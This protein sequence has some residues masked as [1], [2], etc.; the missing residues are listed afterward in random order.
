YELTIKPAKAEFL[1]SLGSG[2]SF[3]CEVCDLSGDGELEGNIIIQW[4][5]NHNKEITSDKDERV[6]V[7]K[8]GT[9]AKKLVIRRII[10]SDAGDYRCAFRVGHITNSKS[11]KLSVFKDMSFDH[12]PNP[13]HPRIH[14]T[15]IIEC[16]VS[17]VPAPEV[18][19]RFNGKKIIYGDKY[20]QL[21]KGLQIKNISLADNGNYTCIAEI[22]DSGRYDEKRITVVV[23]V[24]P[25]MIH[26][27]GHQ[28]GIAG[29]ELSL[30]CKAESDPMPSYEFYKGKNEKLLT[31]SPSDRIQIDSH[32]GKLTFK[33][34][35]KDDH[36]IY[37]C[38]ALNDVGE[39]SANGSLHVLVAPHIY[40]LKNVTAQEGQDAK[41]TC[42]S[43]GDPM[44][45]MEFQ[46]VGHSPF[47]NGSNDGG[48]ITVRHRPANILEIEIK[49][50]QPHDSSN[51]TCLT[52][53]SAGEHNA[54][55]HLT[56]HYQPKFPSDHIRQV[57]SWSGRL[58][59]I[60]CNAHGNPHPTFEWWHLERLLTNNETFNIFTSARNSSLQIRVREADQSWIFGEYICRAKNNKGSKDMKILHSRASLPDPPSDA[61]VKENTPNLLIINVKPPFSVGG[62]KLLGYRIEYN[63]K[64]T[65]F[66][67]MRIS[68]LLL[69]DDLKMENLKP[70]TQYQFKVRSRNEVGVGKY[71][72]LVAT[73]LNIT[74]PYPI[75]L[76][77]PKQSKD[78]WSYKIV[79]EKPKTGGKPIKEYEIRYRRV[80]M[81][82]DGIS[83]PL[84]NWVSKTKDENAYKPS[85]EYILSNLNPKTNY[86]LQI[87][88]KT[89]IGTSTQSEKFIF[90]TAAGKYITN[91]EMILKRFR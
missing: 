60:T 91:F 18:S 10:E 37:R 29:H 7:A 81:K 6:V 3:S 55:S 28:K 39:A 15:A 40:E 45:F 43:H 19:W 72:E 56:V 38:K 42:K 77:S 61:S 5:N 41:I 34:L 13:Q 2:A 22:S 20:K 85:V 76:V 63:N 32:L 49:K 75:K 4:F 51:Y 52:K 65:D 68:N 46:K 25:V 33:P 24:P 74:K 79:W 17:G 62:V 78:P 67:T 58:H 11:I 73:T 57:F 83:E 14:T 31:S 89:D 59:N 35:K 54:T 27:P 8:D 66:T 90:K 44:P 21:T 9:K 1:G 53:N 50:V 47:K 84:E 30:Y 16:Q 23:H 82:Q 70:A 71:R 64:V 86:Q 48:R 80:R 12:A 26:G 88:A 69:G 36:G 87:F